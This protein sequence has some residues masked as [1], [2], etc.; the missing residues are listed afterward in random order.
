MTKNDCPLSGVFGSYTRA[1]VAAFQNKWNIRG[2]G[3]VVSSKTRAKL[4]EL[5]AE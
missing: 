3:T 2:D 5:Y 4:N 1:A